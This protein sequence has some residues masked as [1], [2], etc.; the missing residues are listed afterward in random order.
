M[1]SWSIIAC[2][3]GR[4]IQQ[5]S[6]DLKSIP[7]NGIP[8]DRV[9]FSD[10][11]S[12]I[13]FDVIPAVQEWT[14]GSWLTCLPC[15]APATGFELTIRAVIRCGMGGDQLSGVSV[16]AQI[17]ILPGDKSHFHQLCVGGQS[18]IQ[19]RQEPIASGF[20]K[21]T[22]K[23]GFS[24]NWCYPGDIW[25]RLN[26]VA[27]VGPPTKVTF[28]ASNDPSIY[29][30]Q[31]ER[32]F[33]LAAR[34][35]CL[36]TSTIEFQWTGQELTAVQFMAPNF[37]LATQELVFDATN[38]GCILRRMNEQS[39]ADLQM[40][41]T[42]SGKWRLR[43]NGWPSRGVLEAWNRHIVDPYI[44]SLLTVDA[45]RQISSIPRIEA[46]S[47]LD[48]AS[49]A[50]TTIL[51][52]QAPK[53]LDPAVLVCG[54]TTYSITFEGASVDEDPK[55]ADKSLMRISFP[56]L[57]THTGAPLRAIAQL[58]KLQRSVANVPNDPSFSIQFRHR[59]LDQTNNAYQWVRGGA[60]DL[61]VSPIP[62]SSS[63]IKP[64][65]NYCFLTS[66]RNPDVNTVHVEQFPKVVQDALQEA[67]GES[68]SSVAMARLI[69]AGD[70]VVEPGRPLVYLNVELGVRAM[71]PGG[72]DPTPDERYGDAASKNPRW[73]ISN[74]V[75]EATIARR[76]HREQPVNVF[77]AKQWMQY[78]MGST[79]VAQ[80]AFQWSFEERNDQSSSQSLS[81]R[82]AINSRWSTDLDAV[83]IPRSSVVVLDADP[84]VVAKVFS[85][86]FAP[87]ASK[88]GLREIANWNGQAV[89]G[90]RWEIH[91]ISQGVDLLLPPQ[92]VG[93]AM[94]K[95]KSTSGVSD[96]DEGKTVDFRFAPAGQLK[97]E[98]SYFAQ[99]SAEIPWN[100]RRLLGFPGQHDPG[101]TVPHLRAEWFYGMECRVDDPSLRVCEL[102]ALTGEWPTALPLS[103]PWR[104][105]SGKT[106]DQLGTEQQQTIFQQLRV[107]WSF[108]YAA[109]R[110]RL[111]VLIPRHEFSITGLTIDDP[112]KVSYHLR[113]TAKLRF[114]VPGYN[115]TKLYEGKPGPTPF[116]KG[117]N[118][119][120]ANNVDRGLAGGMTWGFEFAGLADELLERPHSEK[121]HLINPAL[122]ALGGWAQQ[123]A[124]F[125]SGKTTIYAD[126][127]MGR[128]YRYSVE[129][130]GRVGVR[131]NRAKHVIVYERTTLRKDRFE[132][133]QDELRGRPVLR[134]VDEYVEILEEKKTFAPPDAPQSAKV[135]RGCLLATL[136]KSK[137][138]NVD[139]RN[140]G[141]Q[142]T[143]P[144]P[145]AARDANQNLTQEIIAL[146]YKFP[147]WNIDA[148]PAFYP[149]PQ[150]VDEFAA[151]PDA[152]TTGSGTSGA[153]YQE[154][155]QPE[156]L[157]FY[158][159]YVTTDTADQTD[160][161]P[162]VVGVDYVPWQ[163]PQPP[164]SPIN[165]DSN[166]DLPMP[167]AHDVELG[168][169]A[170]TLR[171]VPT[172]M[173]ANLSADRFQ[174]ATTARLNNVM[175]MR[176]PGFKFADQEN[177]WLKFQSNV[178]DFKTTLENIGPKL[179]AKLPAIL[180]GDPTQDLKTYV[181]GILD[182]LKKRFD[183]LCDKLSKDIGEKC[184]TLLSDLA[185]QGLNQF[186][187]VID[188]NIDAL[189]KQL[190]ED[191]G[192]IQPSVTIEQLR[193]QMLRAIDGGFEQA[194]LLVSSVDPIPDQIARIVNTLR[195][196]AMEPVAD[197]VTQV[198]HLRFLID[199]GTKAEEIKRYLN[200][201]Q[202]K[203]G[204]LSEQLR[205][206]T[207][208]ID[209]LLAD[210]ASKNWPAWKKDLD[211]QG[212]LA[213]VSTIADKLKSVL[214]QI[215]GTVKSVQ[216]A[217]V[218][219]INATTIELAGAFA[220]LKT[221]TTA[222]KDKIDA[223]LKPDLGL[224]AV[225]DLCC[226]GQAR[227]KE[228]L[229]VSH[230]RVRNNVECWA[231]TGSQDVTQKLQELQEC[232]RAEFVK[233]KSIVSEIQVPAVSEELLKQLCG[234]A[235]V[236]QI[237]TR[238]KTLVEDVK[239]AV[240][241]AA[242]SWQQLDGAKKV[243]EAWKQQFESVVGT[244]WK[245]LSGQL[246]ELNEVANKVQGYLPAIQEKA[247]NALQLWRAFGERPAVPSLD[248]SRQKL[249]Y[250]FQKAVAGD[251]GAIANDLAVRYSPVVA[252]ADRVGNDLKGLGVSLPTDALREKVDQLAGELP[253][254]DLS[255][256]IPDFG[257]IKL[258]GMF[259]GI[260]I[261][262]NLKDNIKIQQGI[263]KQT[264]RAWLKADV[265]FALADRAILFSI[266][267]IE[268]ATIKPKFEAHSSVSAGI[269]GGTEK[270]VTGIITSDWEIC[271]GGS[272]IITFQ[273]TTLRFD[274]SGKMTFNIDPKK[275]KVSGALDF[276]SSMLA[277]LSSSQNGL[278]LRFLTEGSIPVGVQ[279]LYALPL[280]DLQYGAFGMSNMSFAASFEL[281]FLPK[282]SLGAGF[283]LSDRYSPFTI[284][285]FVLGGAGWIIINTR[286]HP[287]SDPAQRELMVIVSVA[288]ALSASLGI[289]LGPISG[290]VSIYL[291]IN[292]E[293]HKNLIGPASG[294]DNCLIRIFL[295]V[296]GRVNV[297]GIIT[298]SIILSLD[299]TY[300][301]NDGSLTGTGTVEISVKICWCLTI[302]VSSTVHMKFA[303]KDKKSEGS[304]HL[305]N[306]PATLLAHESPEPLFDPFR[307][308]MCT[309]SMVRRM[310]ERNYVAKVQPVVEKFL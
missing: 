87:V 72:Q 168:F 135:A 83:N 191:I 183:D 162:P 17:H 298:V 257:G 218:K 158:S 97:I 133:D 88:D 112:A 262:D 66:A 249:G 137:R 224:K 12:W 207:D 65:L 20:S 212:V 24:L 254:F 309:V 117:E 267:P 67:L 149:K 201:S 204:Q 78:S 220:T 266:G 155:D 297:L 124:V 53:G 203:L 85:P 57:R 232:Y 16:F 293:F 86:M 7:T 132:G 68:T 63:A 222:V 122:S 306:R 255:K 223:V 175:P 233:L 58:V 284:T 310:D 80:P 271:F 93:E 62:T 299:A 49:W 170:F 111:G 73:S 43:L 247:G 263:D 98:T 231:V 26:L 248:F 165:K 19:S 285:I 131:W 258:P 189:Q 264:Q 217:I 44:L 94:E 121:G 234:S 51:R 47:G 101:V 243:A 244:G 154:C 84:F 37:K 253:D 118:A 9:Y 36:K 54:A 141:V 95:Y 134:K 40:L 99:N 194:T 241:Q 45:G 6:P 60:L 161:W 76:F 239:K 282:F 123:K 33:C 15:A 23:N 219:V 205:V 235:Y 180:K 186:K 41:A 64:A 294:Q 139:S 71:V 301:G 116:V 292:L 30:P 55:P 108:L 174:K 193:E 171:S 307:G 166:L 39:K 190:D 260:K 31:F 105:I 28:R 120:E 202:E 82:L 206:A 280:P 216:D 151:D 246:H 277:S 52:E 308:E 127:A 56:G 268:V 142:V 187:A 296:T 3:Q 79:D 185:T 104:G 272:P 164:E 192:R 113:R 70:R 125:C 250:Y 273:Q 130:I 143:G 136:F 128:T 221:A 119:N 209:K 211:Q 13:V 8:I 153:F 176:P 160:L 129:R 110:S 196:R 96:I 251:S 195:S 146:G 265:N 38:V 144:R 14:N 188:Q 107:N 21:L 126:V 288:I 173:R 138:I 147:L 90:P 114:P 199:Q 22:T 295:L 18:I 102:A 261:P 61:L 304:A 215:Q 1:A 238:A 300:D 106:P 237:Q 159:S 286:Y 213:T 198:E 115:S 25:G 184:K 278:L 274:G 75:N 281:M 59:Y 252:W 181:D 10:G 225:W 182:P 109:L 214:A 91:G 46:I 156:K 179:V 208:N 77:D 230:D 240:G 197:V 178:N 283:Q 27:M 89:E 140:W 157:Y 29:T 226:G 291:G 305:Q 103:L 302:H 2:N 177:L 210:I 145:T 256:M 290:T 172:D 81:M 69:P 32:K 287:D 269:S 228:W 259:E 200:V 4:V 5:F 11:S 242:M 276:V 245:N 74:N 35:Q 42:S 289:T 227:V 148:D 100:L 169:E 279:A 236:Q 275:I 48:R 270:S 92:G 229:E 34:D 163:P 152:V 167:S 303:G 150:V 50:I